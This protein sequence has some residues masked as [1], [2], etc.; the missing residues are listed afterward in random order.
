MAYRL[1]NELQTSERDGVAGIGGGR[2]GDKASG[3]GNVRLVAGTASGMGAGTERETSGGRAAGGGGK[4]DE[5]EERDAVFYRLEMLGYRVGQ[6]L[7]ERYVCFFVLCLPVRLDG[8]WEVGNRPFCG[9][10]AR[11]IVRE[12]GAGA[13]EGKGHHDSPKTIAD[14]FIIQLFKRP[15]TFYRYS[16]CDQVPV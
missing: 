16:R 11:G 2:E 10:R 14:L 12:G 15:P 6:G 13:Y 3:N 7:V 4:M 8:G 1:A 9:C 5:D